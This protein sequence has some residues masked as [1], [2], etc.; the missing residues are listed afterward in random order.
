MAV[1]DIGLGLPTSD[2]KVMDMGVTT[3]KRSSLG[4]QIV[5][6]LGIERSFGCVEIGF[7]L[8]TTFHGGGNAQLG[9]WPAEVFVGLDYVPPIGSTRYVYGQSLGAAYKL[10][11]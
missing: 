3:T 1:L 11:L 8:G 7:G 6:S 9:D 2:I 5:P 4:H 10:L